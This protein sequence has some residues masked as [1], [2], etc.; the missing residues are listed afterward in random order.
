MVAISAV[1]Y[2]GMTISFTTASRDTDRIESESDD[3][4]D[5]VPRN[6][7]TGEKIKMHRSQTALDKQRGL[8]FVLI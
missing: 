6:C 2:F 4:S 8:F 5:D 7:I 3:S 1:Q